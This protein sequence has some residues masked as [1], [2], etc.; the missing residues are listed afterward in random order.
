MKQVKAKI[1][2][3]FAALLGLVCIVMFMLGMGA[4]AGLAVVSFFLVLAIAFRSH[5]FLRGFSYT[6]LIFAAVAAA[7]YYPG[8]FTEVGGFNLKNLIVPLLMVIMFG[9][10]SSMSL[11]DFAGVIQ[12]PKGVFVG[13]SVVCVRRRRSFLPVCASRCWWSTQSLRAGQAD[14]CSMT[15]ALSRRERHM[16]ALYVL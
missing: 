7:M 12:M 4:K 2:Y 3:L 8:V 13:K 15:S 16:Y 11:H 14:S 6:V 10:G 5:G 9:M 1:T